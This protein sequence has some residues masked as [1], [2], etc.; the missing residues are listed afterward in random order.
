MNDVVVARPAPALA[1]G[2]A[3]LK[4]LADPKISAEKMQILLQMQKDIMAESRREAFQAAFAAMSAEMPQVD[5]RGIV[6]LVKDNKVLGKYNFAKWEDMDAVIR[7]IMHRHG[8]GLTFP[9]RIEGG[10]AI[11]VGKLLHAGGHY[12]I[13]ER[14][15]T[16]DP[17]PGRNNA[18][19][20][21]SGL[22]YAKRYVAEGLLN[23][24]RRGVDDDGIMSGLKPVDAAQAKQL[25][26][27]LE[28]TGTKVET[29]L[30]MFVT[31]CETLE[32][33]PLR[34]LPRLLN[35]LEEKKR[36]LAQKMKKEQK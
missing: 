10:R 17:G 8:F 2:D 13:S 11:L 36:N 27:L 33:I 5:K 19:A 20:E 35:A 22:S 15:V 29:F 21:G 14:A 6:E 24:V 4:M 16:P 12:E 26:G 31:G 23:I 28:E 1:L 25:A 32:A 18:Q 9:Q 30:K 3:L 34:E 7:P